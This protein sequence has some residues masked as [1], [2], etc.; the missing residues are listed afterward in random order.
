MHSPECR[1]VTPIDEAWAQLTPPAFP[2]Y[3]AG[4][5]GPTEADTLIA[6]DYHRWRRL[7]PSVQQATRNE[8]REQDAFA[9]E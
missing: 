1:I 6:G 4:T 2:N 3:A 7:K 5:S 9:V 8:R